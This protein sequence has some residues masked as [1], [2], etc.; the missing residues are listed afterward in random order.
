MMNG[1]LTV[2]FVFVLQNIEMTILHSVK[3]AAEIKTEIFW[4]WKFIRSYGHMTVMSFI[5]QEP[6]QQAIRSTME[7]WP[8]KVY[9]VTSNTSKLLKSLAQN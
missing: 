5:T 8:K 4:P 6:E 7:S 2:K 9:F 1:H 3:Y